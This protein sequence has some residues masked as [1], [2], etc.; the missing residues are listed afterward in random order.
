MKFPVTSPPRTVG[1]A[2]TSPMPTISAVRD[3]PARTLVIFLREIIRFIPCTLGAYIASNR[4]ADPALRS[5][6]FTLTSYLYMRIR[7]KG[8]T[9]F[10]HNLCNLWLTCNKP[11]VSGCP[12]A[13]QAT[14]IALKFL[15]YLRTPTTMAADVQ[16]LFFAAHPAQ[17]LAPT[18]AESRGK[19]NEH[20]SIAGPSPLTGRRTLAP[21]IRPTSRSAVRRRRRGLRGIASNRFHA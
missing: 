20:P 2:L 14:F 15:V 11:P 18:G 8:G 12:I 4:K 1:S 3:T 19:R 9:G 16:E 21:A 6:T 10:C 5:Q 7:I 13:G 17:N